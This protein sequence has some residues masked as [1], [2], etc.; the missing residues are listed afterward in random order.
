MNQEKT[1]TK[2]Y[3][4]GLS[5]KKADVK[6][7]G[8][9][10]ITK[11]NQKLLLKKAKEKGIEGIFV[12]STCNRTEITGFAKHPFELISLLIKYS[13]GNVEDFINVSNVY[14][15]KDAVKHLFSIGTGLDS[16]ILGDYEIVGQL[17]EAFK[18]A[19]QMGTTNAYLERLMNLV[20]QA[21]KDVKNHT[22]LSSGTTSVAYAAIQYIIENVEDHSD[23]EILIFG[24]GD[25]GK[26]TCK[27]VLNYT[28][29]KHITIIN[30]TLNTAVGF[31][32]LYPEVSVG[33]LTNLKKQIHNSDILIVATGSS[34]PTITKEHLKEGKKL[35]I[36]DLSIPENVDLSVNKIPGITLINVDEL[37]KITDKT[38]ET[39]KSEIPAA[40]KLIE[41]YKAEFNDW[42]SHRKYVPAVNALK[43]S[44]QVIQRDEINF[45]TKKIKDFNIEHAEYI[46]NRIIQK[47]TTQFVK[48]LKDE[49]T[50]VDQSIDVVSR[51]FNLEKT[52]V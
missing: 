46:T 21:S 2:L 42:I 11:E 41:K 15:N 14:K 47:I 5:Y 30:R 8:A 20:L 23:K 51:I 17:K 12:L 33:K 6:V 16:Q 29:N 13:N 39:R 26:N 1:P 7:R 36:L 34:V 48:H 3:N 40:E 44:L 28:S 4:V 35:L 38:I 9:F 24:L 25:I 27:N 19:K 18:L 50:A 10:S 43:A 32:E 22:K 52:E 45:H 37:S 49:N 31:K